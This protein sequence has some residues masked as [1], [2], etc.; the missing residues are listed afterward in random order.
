MLTGTAAPTIA[1]LTEQHKWELLTAVPECMQGVAEQVVTLS[2]D[3]QTQ[4]GARRLAATLL[5]ALKTACIAELAKS[6][7]PD[8]VTRLHQ[9][10]PPVPSAAGDPDSQA[11]E[12]TEVEE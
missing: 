6:N 7:T 12:L 1:R 5:A 9:I 8:L 10:L 2:E 11:A 4:E 3:F